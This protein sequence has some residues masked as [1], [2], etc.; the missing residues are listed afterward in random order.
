MGNYAFDFF[1]A[2][3]HTS[4]SNLTISTSLLLRDNPP[5][6]SVPEPGSLAL[7]GLALMA[8]LRTRRRRA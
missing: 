6:Q 2:E 3:R 8:G 7:A 4:G 5:G 1:F